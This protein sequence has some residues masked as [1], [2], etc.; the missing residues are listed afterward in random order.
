MS[1]TCDK[2]QRDYNFIYKV[3]N[4]IWKKIAPKP[5]TLGN[6]DEHLFGGLL[7]P[8]CAWMTAKDL[9]FHLV[10]TGKVIDI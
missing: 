6:Y 1:D 4:D 7:C 10:F 8:D 9:G 2:C 5:E 3:P